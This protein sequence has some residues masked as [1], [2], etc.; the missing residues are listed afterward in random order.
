MT[1]AGVWTAVTVVG[2][3]TAVCL[4]LVCGQLCDCCWCVDSYVTV[5]GVWTAV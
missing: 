4:L 3:W 1:V 2:D 5:A